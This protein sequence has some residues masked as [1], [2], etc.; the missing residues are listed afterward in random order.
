MVQKYN[1]ILG[2]LIGVAYGDAFGMPAEMWSQNAVKQYFG[3]IEDFLPGPPEN[4]ISK[5][6]LR[7]EVTDDTMN[8]KFVVE[9]LSESNGNVDATL[10]IQKLRNWSNTCDKSIA[11]TGPSTAKAFAQLDAG[12]PMEETGKTGVTNGA[13]MKILPVGFI[14]NYHRLDELVENVTALCLPTH[15]TSAAISGASAIAA[16][17]AYA[18]AGENNLDAM[19][20]VACKAAIL[21]SSKGYEVCAPSVEKRILLGKQLVKQCDSD[22]EAIAAIYDIIGSGLPITESIPAALAMVYLAKG[23]PIL[24]AKYCANLG[25]DTDTVGAMA[26]GICG[27]FSGR[28]A[29]PEEAIT[30]LE[31][32][33]GLSFCAMT[34]RLVTVLKY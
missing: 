27:A 8:T 22:Q 7:G 3:K 11:V 23:N 34:D 19:L 18:V 33:N 5:N 4:M 29:F 26:C 13:A 30:L 28:E 10:F 1:R 9:M 14:A 25:G 12:I 17:G 21:G 6:L 15:N 20:E 16:A 32:V 31:E 24:C 2:G